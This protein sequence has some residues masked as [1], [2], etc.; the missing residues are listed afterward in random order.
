VWTD[1][2]EPRAIAASILSACDPET[3][4]R[5]RIAGHRVCERF[6]WAASARRHLEIYA[7]LLKGAGDFRPYPEPVHA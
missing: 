4:A 7:G 3:A 5:L 2:H 6:T 1:P